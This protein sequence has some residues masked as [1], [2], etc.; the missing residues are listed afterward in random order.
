MIRYDLSDLDPAVRVEVMKEVNRRGIFNTYV[1]HVLSV[2]EEYEAA[3]DELVTIEEL[4]AESQKESEAQYHRLRS[5][6]EAASCETCGRSPAAQL[7]LRRQVGMVVVS[8]TETFESYLC[9]QCGENMR[10]WVQ[11]QSALKGWTG[12]KSA[13][14]N[15]VVLGINERNYAKFLQTLDSYS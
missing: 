7:V 12:V 2:S 14:M 11:K 13:L 6:A 8:K 15:P 5:G 9:R 1:D 10:R 4:R 3:V